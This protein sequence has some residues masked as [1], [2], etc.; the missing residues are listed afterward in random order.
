VTSIVSCPVAHRL[1]HSTTPRYVLQN[2]TLVQHTSH[3]NVANQSVIY[4]QQVQA[5]RC[6]LTPPSTDA[7][8]INLHKRQTDSTDSDVD[9]RLDRCD[10]QGGLI[11]WEPSP[12][13]GNDWEY[14]FK[15]I[16]RLEDVVVVEGSQEDYAYWAR[17]ATIAAWSRASS[18]DAR[19]IA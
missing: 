1:P 3:R 14:I 7:H 6:L 18:F 17:L 4:R 16:I 8:A 11:L 19:V 12:A 13:D 10:Q 9:A 5:Y 15:G 2:V